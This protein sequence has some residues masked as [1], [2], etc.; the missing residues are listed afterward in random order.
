[1]LP[2]TEDGLAGRRPWH[3]SHPGSSRQDAPKSLLPS[4]LRPMGVGGLWPEPSLTSR[5]NLGREKSREGLKTPSCPNHTSDYANQ[6]AG[7]IILPMR[8][9]VAL[10]DDDWGVRVRD[11]LDA[12][13]NRSITVEQN[14]NP[15]L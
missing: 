1:M 12:F 13:D 14:E 4:W 2:E 8:G 7:D 11:F 10:D 15:W 3:A 9:V 5:Q 6:F